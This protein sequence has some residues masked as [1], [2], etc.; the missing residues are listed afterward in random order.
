VTPAKQHYEKLKG[1]KRGSE[2]NIHTKN[3]TFYNA[4]FL[5]MLTRTGLVIFLA[6][7]FYKSGQKFHTIYCNEI[8]SLDLPVSIQGVAEEDE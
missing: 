3:R 4:I 5:N 2:V 7:P 6:D 8:T 1:L